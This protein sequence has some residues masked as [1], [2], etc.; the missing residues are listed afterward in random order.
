MKLLKLASLM[1]LVLVLF[2]AGCSSD[3][4]NP[5][6][7]TGTNS[8]VRASSD[9]Y[10]ITSVDATSYDNFAYYS[11]ADKDVVDLTDTDAASSTAWDM[12]FERNVVVT[13]S[14][15]SG[16]GSI[17]A[18]DLTANGVSK[19][20]ADVTSADLAGLSQSDWVADGFDLVIDHYYDYNP[21]THVLTPTNLVYAMRDAQGG[22]LKFQITEFIGGG[23]PPAMANFVIKYVYAGSTADLSGP[24]VVD[25]VDGS[26]GTF[27]YDFSAGQATN[28]ADPSTSL[29]W[30][31]KVENYDV[32]LNSSFSGP[33]N[34]G[35]NPAYTLVSGIDSTDFAA[36]T[37]VAADAG[38]SYD[39]DTPGSVFRDWY[40]YANEVLTTK[41][42]VYAIKVGSSTYKVYIETYYGDNG[43]HA[44]YIFWW[45]PL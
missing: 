2:I 26:S 7:P 10:W 16:P 27:Y 31:I 4:S 15:I 36:Y 32:Y 29:D 28:P 45:E 13:N 33:G 42:H 44:T 38:R 18:A 35:A 9:N 23:A 12:G 24:V 21:T 8:T 25:T 14:G 22:Y 17:V 6:L 34:A 40:D 20:F 30:D 5:V 3:K 19:S 41:G 43:I 37:T 39:Q 11:F 1:I